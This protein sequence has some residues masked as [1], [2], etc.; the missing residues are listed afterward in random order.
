MSRWI[1]LLTLVMNRFNS[2]AQGCRHWCAT[3][4][5]KL[6]VGGYVNAN[7]GGDYGMHEIA[8]AQTYGEMFP[9]PG[10]KGTFRPLEQTVRKKRFFV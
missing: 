9:L 3:A 10:I 4:L 5:E 7:V 1:D 2:I 8:S 6:A